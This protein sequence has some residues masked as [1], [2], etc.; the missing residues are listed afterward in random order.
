[1]VISSLKRLK[2]I[3]IMDLS[4]LLIKVPIITNKILKPQFR[5]IRITNKPIKTKPIKTNN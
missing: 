5:I 4:R 2:W 3:L 1:M